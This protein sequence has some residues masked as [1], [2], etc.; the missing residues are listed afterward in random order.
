[1]FYTTTLSWWHSSIVKGAG[2]VHVHSRFD[3]HLCR[4]IILISIWNINNWYWPGCVALCGQGRVHYVQAH[5]SGRSSLEI[6]TC[7]ITMI[8]TGWLWSSKPGEAALCTGTHVQMIPAWNPNMSEN[9]H[10]DRLVCSSK[11][12]EVALCTGTHVQWSPLEIRTCRITM[13]LTNWCALPSP[14]RLH[15][16]RAHTSRRSLLETRTCL[17]TMILTNW[18]WSSKPGEAALCTNTLPD[19]PRLKSG[20]QNL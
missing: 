9:H 7:Q 20:G 2:C 12:G 15:Y 14:G 4:P 13:I 19:D 5:T 17:R 1:M 3:S 8:L 18:L 6:R 10:F 16:A 11:P